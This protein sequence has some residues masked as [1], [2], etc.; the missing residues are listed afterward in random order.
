MKIVCICESGASVNCIAS[1]LIH[2]HEI[3]MVI[4]P[5][6]SA[7]KPKSKKPSTKKKRPKKK[8]NALS[9][10]ANR[11]FF[12]VVPMKVSH[13]NVEKEIHARAVSYTHLTLPTTPYV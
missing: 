4:V 13:E 2:D 3:A 1:G 5:D 6:F 8:K 10:I 12:K 9:R 11:L 7:T